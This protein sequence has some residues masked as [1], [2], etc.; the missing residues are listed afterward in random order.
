MRVLHIQKVAGVGGSER[1][2]LELL[3]GLASRGVD[4]RMCVLA[5]GSYGLFMDALRS[6]EVEVDVLPASFDVDPLLVGKIVRRIRGF[7]PDL[8]HTHL[9]HADVHGQVAA[10]VAGVPA[11]SSIHSAQELY[12]RQP[13]LSAARM[14]GHLA[15]RTIAISN[16]VG[17]YV[18]RFRLA[19]PD[20]VR[21][22]H[23]G[24]EG[25]R[26]SLPEHIRSAVRRSL[27]VR[28][29]EIVVGMASRL[30]PLK[31][32]DFLMEAFAKACREVDGMR[33][34]IAGDGPLRGELEQRVKKLE[35]PG[36]AR[37]LGFVDDVPSF[38]SACDIVAF[39]SLPGLGEGFGLAALEAMAAGRPVVATS[40]DSLPEIVVDGETGRLVE[41]GSTES[42]A[43]IL[44]ELGRDRELRQDLGAGARE[45]AR[46]VFN[47]EAM[48][49]KT[50]AVYDEVL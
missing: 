7:D 31:G 48:V 17:E 2:L 25:A 46:T 18:K 49:E 5:V 11:I 45:R 20:T 8:V 40:T 6:R 10:R 43:R 39:T 42:L 35:P 9:I 26:W 36:A 15:Q 28:P 50:L 21:L 22:V 47:L 13:Y 23:Y 19:R 1:H 41:P 4:V 24:I 32:H 16:S 34:L 38:M 12:R 14:A 30:I 33:L 27:S 37:L 44:V 3:P 29:E